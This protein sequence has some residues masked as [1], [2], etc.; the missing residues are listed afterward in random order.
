L[1]GNPHG[2]FLIKN[3]YRNPYGKYFKK[4]SV[5]VPHENLK[6]I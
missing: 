3:Y 5:G 4:K 2:K 6:N 1:T